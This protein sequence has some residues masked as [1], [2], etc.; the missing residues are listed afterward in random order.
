MDEIDLEGFLDLCAERGIPVPPKALLAS[1]ARDW[2]VARDSGM[3]HEEW[4]EMWMTRLR[5]AKD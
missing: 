1:L 2:A 5:K 3:S 4:L